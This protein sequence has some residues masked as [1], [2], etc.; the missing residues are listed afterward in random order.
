VIVLYHKRV[1]NNIAEIY[2]YFMN[3]LCI[4]YIYTPFRD[5]NEVNVCINIR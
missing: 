4:Y 5:E 1:I 2:E 3:I